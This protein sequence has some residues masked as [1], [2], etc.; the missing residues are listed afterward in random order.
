[1]EFL[2]I[3]VGVIL[4][5][6]IASLGVLRFTVIG[7]LIVVDRPDNPSEPY[8]CSELNRP[9]HTFRRKKYVLMRVCARKHNSHE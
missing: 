4:G 6:F 1:M 8:L 7:D 3:C 5:L 2:W 9:V